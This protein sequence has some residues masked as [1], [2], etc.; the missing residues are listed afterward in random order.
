MDEIISQAGFI[1]YDSDMQSED[2]FLESDFLLSTLTELKGECFY[3][4]FK[5]KF[6]YIFY[7]LLRLKQI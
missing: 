5:G 1:V 3:Q 2:M 4:V 6:I 7:I